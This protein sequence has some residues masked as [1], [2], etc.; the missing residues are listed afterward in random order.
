M[1]PIEPC[2]CTLAFQLG[3]FWGRLWDLRWRNFARESESLSMGL[4]PH[5]LF[6]FFQRPGMGRQCDHAASWLPGQPHTPFA[7]PS[8]PLWTVPL[9]K[10]NLTPN[11]IFHFPTL[12]LVMAFYRS[13]GKLHVGTQE[14]RFSNALECSD[15]TYQNTVQGR[16]QT[17]SFLCCLN[18]LRIQNYRFANL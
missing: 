7:V 16:K 9:W 10:S 6:S 1:S 13:N 12:L 18:L 14:S 15:C 3:H 8:P 17:L 5:F 4:G 11:K 2:I